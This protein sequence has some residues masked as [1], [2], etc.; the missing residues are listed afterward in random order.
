MSKR[1]RLDFGGGGEFKLIEEGKHIGVLREVHEGQSAKGNPWLRMKLEMVQHTLEGREGPYHPRCTLFLG[2]WD[3]NED[4]VGIVQ[5]AFAIPRTPMA[6]AAKKEAWITAMDKPVVVQMVHDPYTNKEGKE[7]TAYK[8]IDI[9][10]YSESSDIFTP[11]IMPGS[12]VGEVVRP[13]ET[14]EPEPP[15]A[16]DTVPF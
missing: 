1:G 6:D 9:F 16:E 8:V 3:G 13:S 2:F 7:R 10:R 4:A 12:Q 15:P 14:E 5:D 11:D